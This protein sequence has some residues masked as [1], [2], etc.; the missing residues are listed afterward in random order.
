MKKIVS[1]ML[2]VQITSGFLYAQQSKSEI[3]FDYGMRLYREGLYDLAY[4][5]FQNYVDNYP[6][7]PHSAEAQFLC[8]E[9]AFLI[10]NY[11]DA[12]KSFTIF[13]VQ[14]STSDKADLAQFRIGECFEKLDSPD[15]ALNAYLR[16]DQYHPSSERSAQ[17]LY[18]AARLSFQQKHFKKAESILKQLLKK[19]PTGETLSKSLFLSAEVYSKQEAFDDAIQQ[20][21]RLADKPVLSGDAEKANY[22]LGQIYQTLGYW[23]ESENAYKRILSLKPQNKMIARANFQLGLLAELQSQNGIALSY[24]ENA[25]EKGVDDEIRADSFFH[26]GMLRYKNNDYQKSLIAFEKA[27]KLYPD[28]DQKQWAQI[29]MGKCQESLSKNDLALRIYRNIINHTALSKNK[30]QG[31]VKTCLLFAARLYFEMGEYQASIALYQKYLEIFPGDL[32]SDRILLKTGTICQDKLKLT[33]EALRIFDRF[34][35]SFPENQLIPEVQYHYAEC[36][37]QSDRIIEAVE[38]L[39]QIQ[40]LYPGNEWAKQSDLKLDE[41]ERDYLYHSEKSISELTSLIAKSYD[42][43]QDENQFYLLGRIYF[44]NLK[45]YS[46]AI[47]R[48][49]KYRKDSNDQE[50]KRDALF[51]MGRGYENLF[52]KEENPVFLDSAKAIYSTILADTNQSEKA[53]KAGIRLADLVSKKDPKD[54]VFILSDLLGKYSEMNAELLSKM[55]S[56]TQRQDSLK[57][58]YRYY[59]RL[60]QEYPGSPFYENALGQCGQIL[61]KLGDFTRADSLFKLYQTRFP[62]GAFLPENS[63]CQSQI[64]ERENRIGKA[65]SILEGVMNRFDYAPW[66]YRSAMALGR[67]YLDQNDFRN[68]ER[69]Y[70]NALQLDSLMALARSIGLEADSLSI[71]RQCLSGLAKAYTGMNELKKAKNTYYE[72]LKADLSSQNQSRVFIA[73]ARISEREKDNV[74]A[75]D[76]LKRAVQVV[77]DDSSYQALGM[78]QF[79]LENYFDA[80]ASFDRAFELSSSKEQQAF[81][82]SRIIIS[83]LRQDQI[84]QAQVRMNVYEKTYKSERNFKESMAEIFMEEG[85]AY[86]REKEFDSAL[87]SFGKVS[88]KYKKSPFAP[89]AEFEIGRTYLV[90]NKIEKALNVLTEIIEKYPTHSILAKVYVNLGDHYFRSQQFDNAMSA[91]TKVIDNYDDEENVQIAMRYLIRTYDSVRMWDAALALTRKYIERFP[92]ADDIVQKWVQIGLFY[93]RLNSYPQAIQVFRDVQMDADAETEAEIQYWIAKC[94]NDMGDFEQAIF[95]F[96]KVKYISKPT[97]LPWAS[98]ALYE[99]GMAYLKLNKSEEAIK[100]FEKVV[101]S[102][103]ATSDMGRIAKKRI[104]EIKAGIVETVE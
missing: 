46:E 95:E 50:K 19:S 72:L 68:T 64:A 71:R 85:K 101:R 84:P 103:G 44:D 17:S 69:I 5:Q 30:N 13:I 92:E 87:E 94:C 73:L 52:R 15:E 90:T 67:L 37:I 89:E 36:L 29:W 99:A 11:R 18:E 10:Q 6:V 59:N 70:S 31:M 63:I 79:R 91:F 28:S 12:L 102:E 78:Y 41:V 48:F 23:Q 43:K 80:R 55:G 57:L 93:M 34:L 1:I 3:E 2:W 82:A 9:S 24:F 62:E 86:F 77:P 100:L 81:L 61:F 98:T 20:L 104:D 54:A 39:N 7:N 88:S 96:L 22:E 35:Q 60:V 97:K 33:H 25:G 14:Y 26:L 65:V 74:R 51:Y 53:I 32:M 76:Y 75:A 4:T 21:Q 56:L 49:R 40:K 27:E 16:V 83:M 47:S 38:V 58:T 45:Q 42:K 66:N 8:A